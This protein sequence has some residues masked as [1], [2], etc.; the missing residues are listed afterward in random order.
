MSSYIEFQ[1]VV[2]GNITKKN[3]ENRR[4]CA[5]LAINYFFIR[6][7]KNIVLIIK[8]IGLEPDRFVVPS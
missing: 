6:M 4:F 1:R 5:V 3:K 2:A 7:L 8:K